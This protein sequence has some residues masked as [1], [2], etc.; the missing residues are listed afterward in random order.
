MITK[1]HSATIIVSDQEKA[2]E[3]YTEV[4]GWEKREDNLLPGGYRFL[5]V[6]PRGGEM[7]LVLG[8]SETFG[9]AE[10][11]GRGISLLADDVQA[12]YDELSS[13]GVTF[14]MKPER[15]PWGAI[16]A[17]FSDPDGNSFYLNEAD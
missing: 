12:T 2:L 15:M 3:F 5:T 10:G 4:L 16:G 17:E 13:K 11:V 7:S 9:G 6:G 1:V 14:G 8:K